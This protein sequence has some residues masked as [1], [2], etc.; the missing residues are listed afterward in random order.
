MVEQLGSGRVIYGS[1]APMRDPFPQF[2]WVVYADISEEA[3][4]DIIGRNMEKI[5]ARVK[6]D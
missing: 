2:G 5:I 3:K 6:I 4:R 1:D